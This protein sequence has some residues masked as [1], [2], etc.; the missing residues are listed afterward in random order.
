MQTRKTG[1]A[2]AGTVIL[3]KAKNLAG[4]SCEILAWGCC[5]HWKDLLKGEQEGPFLQYTKKPCME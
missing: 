4:Y 3:G 1:D 5:Y 2:G